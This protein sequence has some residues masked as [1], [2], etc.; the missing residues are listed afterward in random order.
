MRHRVNRNNF[1]RTGSHRKAMFRNMVASLF[2]HRRIKTTPQKAKAARRIAEKLITLAKKAYAS[3]TTAAALHYR[4]RAIST[5]GG[6]TRTVKL[7]FS[8]IGPQ[9]MNRNGGYTRIL[10]LP[11]MIRLSA[12]EFGTRTESNYRR[13]YGWRLGDGAP[14]VFLEL[15]EPEVQE[16]EKKR[17]PQKKRRTKA[18]DG[19]TEDTAATDEA[20]DAADADATEAGATEAKADATEADATEAD[21]DTAADAEDDSGDDAGEASGEKAADDADKKKGK[22]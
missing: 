19:E 5:L 14:Q 16:K 8:E 1:G 18:D 2:D 9:Y 6:N 22:D 15:V 17:K 11:G 7:L 20:T 21:D 12:R 13:A 4:R 3:D 10:Q